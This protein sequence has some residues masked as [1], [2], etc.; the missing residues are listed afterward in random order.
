MIGYE[1]LL[2]ARECLPSNEVRDAFALAYTYLSNLWETLSPDPCLG[3]YTEDYK[4]LTQVYES[5]KPPSGTGKLLWAAL[6][7][8]TVELIHQNV[9]VEAVRDDLETLVLDEEILENFLASKDPKKTVEIESRITSR[10]RRL[11][12]HQQFIELSK[13]LE[14]LKERHEKGLLSS[15]EFLKRL[16]ALAKDVVAAGK[17]APPRKPPTAERPH[18]RTFS[19]MSRTPIRRLWWSGS[20]ETSTPS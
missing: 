7:A 14:D 10:L 1:G 17:E 20:W 19:R 16:L 13:R 2:A 12:N 11:K 9:H 8:K 18:W 15:I 6:G 5:I 4:W 3:P